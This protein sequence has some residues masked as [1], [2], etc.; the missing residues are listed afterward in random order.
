MRLIHAGLLDDGGG[1]RN[2]ESS[3]RAA[4]SSRANAG[5]RFGGLVSTCGPSA[6]S[7]A[8][9]AER[10]SRAGR[11]VKPLAITR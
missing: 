9:M 10:V 4:R 5:C 2:G 3:L 7:A 6:N 8:L 11:A 1:A